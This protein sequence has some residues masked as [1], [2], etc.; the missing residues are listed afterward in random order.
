MT[1]RAYEYESAVWGGEEDESYDRGAGGSGSFDGPK[2]R[3]WLWHEFDE[4]SN[5]VVHEVTTGF[6]ENGDPIREKREARVYRFYDDPGESGVKSG[7]WFNLRFQVNAAQGL[8]DIASKDEMPKGCR[9]IPMLSWEDPIIDLVRPYRM[10]T[11]DRTGRVT[12]SQVALGLFV[13]EAGQC[14]ILEMTKRQYEMLIDELDKIR[15]YSRQK[16]MSFKG[17]PLTIVKK[18]SKGTPGATTLKVDLYDGDDIPTLGDGEFPEPIDLGDHLSEIREKIAELI[19]KKLGPNAPGTES[20]V[21]RND[22]PATP[23]VSEHQKTVSDADDVDQALLDKD[24]NAAPV[25][26]LRQLLE[27][28]GV[29]FPA[30]SRRAGLIKLAAEHKLTL[31]DLKEEEAAVG[32]DPP[33]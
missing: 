28:N 7:A 30:G 1:K 29:E 5:P 23:L 25:W 17:V 8:I 20:L 33:F 2:Y 24:L 19:T 16:D 26:Q 14:Q 22:E 18:G 9:S 31:D 12:P 11:S 3:Q 13:D 32:D 10:N 15:R 27:Q 4:H 6:K 21:E